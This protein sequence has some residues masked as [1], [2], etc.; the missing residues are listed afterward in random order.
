M[1]DPVRQHFDTLAGAG[2]LGAG[3]GRVVSGRA[4]S[5]AQGTEVRFEWRVEGGRILEARFLAYGCPWTLAA[6][7][8]L[9]AQLA[10]RGR[11][12]PWP[13]D[14]EAWAR[15]LGIPLERLGRL[16]VVE[17]ALRAT[18]GAWD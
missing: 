9:V 12:T 15:A 16:L 14:P 3:P 7:D 18:L 17:D 5:R 11:E 4:G 13:G 2:R 6:C 10:G 1:S 8:W